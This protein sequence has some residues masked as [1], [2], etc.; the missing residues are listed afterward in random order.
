M[1]QINIKQYGQ[2]TE[3]FYQ[4]SSDVA[5]LKIDN[6]ERISIEGVDY[7]KIEFKRQKTGVNVS[8]RLKRNVFSIIMLEHFLGRSKSKYV[9]PIITNN[10]DTFE[11]IISCSNNFGGVAI[12]WV[13]KAFR[14]INQKTI[15][16][17]A[18]YDKE[19]PL[20]DISKVVL[21]TA[22]HS[23]ASNYLN[24]EGATVVGA[25]SLLARSANTIATYIHQ[26]QGNKEIA[27]AVSFLDD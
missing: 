3:C 23:F 6:C 15:E 26:L 11:K 2:V 12:K 8:V 16:Y 4:I 1:R 14:V 17:N 20:V 25:A 10:A 5:L 27:N 9:Y 7:W 18:K 19:E 21:Y 22:R 24:S 13:R